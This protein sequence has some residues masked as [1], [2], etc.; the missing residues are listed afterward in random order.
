[1]DV[2]VD[3]EDGCCNRFDEKM[4]MSVMDVVPISPHMRFFDEGWSEMNTPMTAK[5]ESSAIIWVDIS[6]D[7]RRS[8]GKNDIH[9]RDEFG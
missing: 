2:R 9:S 8:L 1:M 6:A 4:T 3:A 7:D 5:V